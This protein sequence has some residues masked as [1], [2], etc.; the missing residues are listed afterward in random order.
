MKKLR[1]VNQTPYIMKIWNKIRPLKKK[2]KTTRKENNIKEYMRYT[3]TESLKKLI[4][5]RMRVF[6][7]FAL[8]E[9]G[10]QNRW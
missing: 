5:G 4:F 8:E 1:K 6:A 10:K 3:Y 7:S 9:E 2:K